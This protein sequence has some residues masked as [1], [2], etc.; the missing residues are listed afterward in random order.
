MSEYIKKIYQTRY[1]WSYLVRAELKNK[2]RRS[3]LGIFWTFLNPL[4]L[5]ALMSTVFGVVFKMSFSDYAPYV[6]SG[7][8]VW[9]LISSSFIGGGHS[10]MSGEQY[11]R[12]FNHP[13][14]IYTLK[15]ALVF[16]ITF[17]IAMASLALWVVFIE[18]QN[19]I[20]GIV[21][22]PLTTLLYFLLSWAITTIAGFVNAKYRDYPQVMA[23]VIQAVWYVSPVFFKRE[24]F[25]SSPTLATAFYL[26]P[27]THILNLVRNPF[28][29]GIMPSF[30]DYFFTIITIVIF[31]FIAGVLNKRN[32]HKVIFYL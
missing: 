4:L 21:T 31:A 5:T 3:K 30:S 22:L 2:F 32:Q 19:I 14:L 1:F 24:M 20:L 15:T 8:I 16:T 13:V 7:L 6:L 11:I 12:Q 9:E 23:L 28:L 29:N 18:P 27:I 26:N 17:I 10:I 25:I